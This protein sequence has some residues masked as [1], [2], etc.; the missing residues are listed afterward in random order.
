M[1][2]CYYVYRE[3]KLELNILILIFG[4]DMLT[5]NVTNFMANGRNVIISA[6]NTDIIDKAVIGKPEI[7]SNLLSRATTVI[8]Y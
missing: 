4:L 1:S 2:L 5:R 6:N 3:C 8:D 7:L